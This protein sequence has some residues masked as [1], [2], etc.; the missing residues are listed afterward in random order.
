MQQTKLPTIPLVCHITTE[1]GAVYTINE[2]RI[3]RHAPTRVVGHP[4]PIT[5]QEF[6][7]LDGPPVV[8]RRFHF[9]IPGET[10][11]VLTARI[12]RISYR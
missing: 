12:Q 1:N 4:E 10:G 5:Q 6:A 8:G 7:P 9:Q 3:T 11:S 2:G